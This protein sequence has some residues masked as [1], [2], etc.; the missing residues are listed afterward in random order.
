MCYLRGIMLHYS[1]Q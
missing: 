1:R